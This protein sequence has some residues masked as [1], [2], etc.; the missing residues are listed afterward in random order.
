M[1]RI[2]EEFDREQK[3]LKEYMN[4]YARLLP[5]TWEFGGM[6]WPIKQLPTLDYFKKHYNDERYALQVPHPI[7]GRTER[8]WMGA[9]YKI[10][11]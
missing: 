6:K 10:L 5:Y 8:Y 7:N 11:L 9:K 1:N 2:L 3:I 4:I